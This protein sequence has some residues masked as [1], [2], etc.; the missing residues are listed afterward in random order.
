[1]QGIE[2]GL[3]LREHA[4]RVANDLA[5]AAAAL[6]LAERR[7]GADP[8]IASA[9]ARLD[10]SAQVQRL[11]CVRPSGSTVDLPSALA[12]LCGAMALAHAGQEGFAINVSGGSLPV[13]DGDGDA[14]L[15]AMCVNELVG[16]ALRHAGPQGGHGGV[17]VEVGDDGTSTTVAVTD[18]GGPRDWSR[19]GGQ[20]TGIVDQLAGCLGGTVVRSVSAAGGR[21]AIAMPSL[22][23][24][25]ADILEDA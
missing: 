20:G 19:T 1:M 25:A 8:M 11:L 12:Q 15:I 17:C 9:I 22:I 16:N 7:V 13:G 23:A 18:T 24:T 4:H 2:D 3:L 10:A 6:R 5:V 14:R 21:V